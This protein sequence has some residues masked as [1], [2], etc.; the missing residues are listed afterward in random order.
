MCYKAVS[1]TNVA[2]QLTPECARQC[3]EP[4]PSPLLA[5]TPATLSAYRLAMKC[6]ALTVRSSLRLCFAI[7][8]TDMV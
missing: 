4:T 7:S 5:Y 6:P 8:G 3:P 1:G 2:Y